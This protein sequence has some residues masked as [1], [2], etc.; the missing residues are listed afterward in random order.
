MSTPVL[1]ERPSA[2]TS[3][4]PLVFDSPH[5]GHDY[6]DDMNA[7]VPIQTLRQQ[8]DAFVDA[9]FGHVPVLGA[10]LLK[11]TFPRIYIDPNRSSE[12][13]QPDALDGPWPGPINNTIKVKRGAGLIY[14]KVHGEVLMYD[15]KLTVAEVQHR[16]DTYWKPY[17][18][19]LSREL[20]RLH[21]AF[22]AVW[23]VNCH[24][25]P[26]KGNVH[27]EDG[28]AER[29]DFV[30]GDRDGT[31]CDSAFT[32]SIRAFMVGKGYSVAINDP[33]KGVELVRKHGRPN[34]ARHSL[35]IEVNRRLYMDEVAIEKNA[36]YPETAAAIADMNAH[37]A[38]FVRS[39]A[40]I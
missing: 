37:I 5:S 4:L 29:A 3:E 25:M 20:D 15:R 14:T 40:S 35:Q 19:A 31:T 18:D 9:L 17:H 28:P 12:D 13:I 27:T 34:E 23:H 30:L 39:R 33:M 21:E 2:G 16:I 22:G 6:P 26:A 11:A 1:I 10:V 38:D 24:S 32:E 7:V 8:E 36:L